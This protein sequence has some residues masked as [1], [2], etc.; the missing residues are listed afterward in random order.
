MTRSARLNTTPVRVGA[1]ALAAMVA[2][3]ATGCRERGAVRGTGTYA[4][5]ASEMVPRIERVTGLHYKTPPAIEPRSREQVR[6]FLVQQFKDQVADSQLAGREV[7]YK[8]LGMIPDTLQLERFLT[9]LLT[10]QIAGFYDPHT[11]VLYVVQ[12]APRALTSVV[13]AHE[14]IH[15]LQDQYVNLDSLERTT[16]DNDRASAVQAVLEGQA[17]LDQIEAMTG[18]ADAL[19]RIPGAWD[20]IRDEIRNNRGED[21]PLF[22]AAPLFIR[23]SLL[24]PYLS[25]AEFMRQ[26]EER[27]LGEMPYDRMPVSTEQI[28]HI[29]AYFGSHPDTPTRVTLPPA[30]GATVRYTD[31]LGE[32]ETRLFIYLHTRDQALAV[33]AA[34]GWDGDRYAVLRTPAG[35]GI[36]WATVWDSP[37]DGAEFYDAVRSAIDHRFGHP[38][39]TAPSSQ[40]VRYR[41]DGRT[42]TVWGGE[43]RGRQVV[44][45]TDVPA[46]AEPTPIDV[47]GVRYGGD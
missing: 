33:R 23:E 6:E 5:E 45:Y 36:V 40:S 18:G 22:N 30:R 20:R 43:V 10:E 35:D 13:I 47:R 28:L 11:K 24:F 12:D 1:L 4:R 17:M 9:D 19:E 15:A 37:L 39:P 32:F 34:A 8:R 38:T 29:P 41:V 27:L 16:T 2:V 3:L 46:G 21:M 42:I 14:L 26:Y 44:L 25:G 7:A 31:D